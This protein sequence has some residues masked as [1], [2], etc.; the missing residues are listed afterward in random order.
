MITGFI[1]SLVT[2][3]VGRNFKLVVYKKRELDISTY[4][5]SLALTS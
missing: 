3:Q 2:F 1:F 4:K 5:A